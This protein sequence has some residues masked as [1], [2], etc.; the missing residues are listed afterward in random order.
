MKVPAEKIRMR[1]ESIDGYSQRRVYKTIAGAQNF[2][3]HWIGDWGEITHNYAVSSDG[4]G[5]V[6]GNIDLRLLEWRR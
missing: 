2:L 4:V 1:Y 6:T 5:K 3:R